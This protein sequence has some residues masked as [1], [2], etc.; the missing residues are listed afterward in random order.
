[1]LDAVRRVFTVAPFEQ[2]LLYFLCG[3]MYSGFWPRFI[4]HP[5]LYN[6]RSLRSVTR[7]GINYELD[8]SCLMQWYV[9]WGFKEKQR[10]RLYSLVNE[11]DV[12]LDVGTNIGETLLNFARMVGPS[13]HVYGFEPDD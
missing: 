7:N 3:T 9:Y 11:G 1:M 5:H 6:Y 4:P 8:I 13:G 12:V 10:D 2:V